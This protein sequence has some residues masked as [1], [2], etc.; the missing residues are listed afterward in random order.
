[1][2]RRKGQSVDSPVDRQEARARGSNG[3]VHHRVTRPS[4]AQAAAPQPPRAPSYPA[5]PFSQGL[6]RDV[7]LRLL[8]GPGRFTAADYRLYVQTTHWEIARAEAYAIHGRFCILCDSPAAQVHHRPAGYRNLFRE[9]PRL[10]L[11]PLC[12]GCHRRHHGK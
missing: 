3:A 4:P 8:A 10:H 7:T 5:D 11:I 9:D 1:L 6:P 2:N 12:R